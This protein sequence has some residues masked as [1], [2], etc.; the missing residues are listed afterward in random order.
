MSSPRS[1]VV[2]L[3]LLGWL[4]AGCDVLL[5]FG[6]TKP[7]PDYQL[8]AS[9][10]TRVVRGRST[11]LPVTVVRPLGF[12]DIVNVVA[13]DLPAGVAV[14]P[15]T[16]EVTDT[17]G[18]FEISASGQAALGPSQL[19]LEGRSVSGVAASASA[20]LLVADP[21]GFVDQSYGENGL[22]RLPPQNNGNASVVSL[23][24][25]SEGRALALIDRGGSWQVIRIA[26]DGSS[27]D[28]AFSSVF[29]GAPSGLAIDA[30]GRVLVTG[31]DN[32]SPPQLVLYRFEA[33]GLALD[34]SFGN[35]GVF[36]HAAAA[37]AAQGIRAKTADDGDI[38]VA[39]SDGGLGVLLL[40]SDSGEAKRFQNGATLAR[41]PGFSALVDVA[42]LP[43]GATLVAA[44][45]ALAVAK[46]LADGGLDSAFGGGNGIATVATGADTQ[47]GSAL[48]IDERGWIAVGGLTSRNGGSYAVANFTAEG[49]LDMSFGDGGL[50]LGM[51]VLEPGTLNLTVPARVTDMAWSRGQLVATLAT[52][53]G[54]HG[55]LLR[56]D[57]DGKGDPVFAGRSGDGDGVISAVNHVLQALAVTADGRI[58]TAGKRTT[59]PVGP[60]A[61]RYW[62]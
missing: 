10:G 61:Q 21:P 50:A 49:A 57:G 40:V 23:A 25:D 43:G 22:S 13:N 37:G 39:G 42:P 51:L 24:L 53:S 36:R 5:G 56:L 2:A 30:A 19:T 16:I 6:S 33:A 46:L 3:L 60:I 52:L 59:V 44:G 7:F 15:G 54:E 17:E 47:E 28:G 35:A 26:A 9:A 27:D 4:A 14:A 20:S 58:L 18:V 34:P 62:D 32:S 45:D 41:V 55:A 48:S 11:M 1:T 31:S 38:L 12:K 8:S 29:A